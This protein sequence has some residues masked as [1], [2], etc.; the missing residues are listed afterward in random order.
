M[1]KLAIYGL[2]GSG[3]STTAKI[4]KDYYE[5]E[6]KKVEFVKL[7]YPLYKI[8]Q[9]F[10]ETAGKKIDFYDQDQVLL[11]VIAE[12]LRKISKTAL[13]DDFMTRL[14]ECTADVVINDDIRDHEHDYPVLKE[15]NFLFFRV[16]CDEHLRIKRLKERNDISIQVNS[17]TTRDINKFEPDWEIDSSTGDLGTTKKKIY[18]ILKTY[19]I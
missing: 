18:D 6:N 4:I 11:E 12:N 7:A 13:V 9:I 3:K 8:Q 10:Y 16:F 14:K 1:L 2:S 5:K 15:E 19:R 17:N